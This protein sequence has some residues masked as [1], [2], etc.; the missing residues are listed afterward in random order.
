MDKTVGV[1]G[2]GQLGRMFM[3]AANRLNI[4]VNILD[5]PGAPAKQIRANSTSDPSSPAGHVDGSFKDPSSVRQLASTSDVITVE[6]E[7]VNTEILEEIDPSS[8]KVHPS[9]KTIRTIQDKFLQKLHLGEHGIATAKSIALKEGTADELERLAAELGGLPVMLKSRREAYDGRGNFAVKTKEDFPAALQALSATEELYVEQ[10]AEFRMEM[11]VI[12]VKTRDGVLSFP[13]VE[14]VHENSICKLVYAPARGVS[15]QTNEKAQALARDAVAAF[16]GKG[17][18]AVEMF[19]LQDGSLLVNEIAPRPHNSGH[20]TIEACGMS[21]YEAHLRAILDLPIPERSLRIKLPAVMLNILGAEAPDSHLE[22]ARRALSNPDTSIHL[23]GKGAARKGRKMGHVTVTAAS[24]REAED[25][26]APLVTF[27]DHQQQQQQQNGKDT[28]AAASTSTSTSQPTTPAPSPAAPTVAVVMGSD[29]DLP[30]LQAGLDTLDSFAIPHTVRITSAHR[31]PAWM[32]EYAAAAAGDGIKVI[33]AAAGGAAHLPG[34]AA[35]H[36]PLP[37]IG[38]PIK[39]SIGDGMDSLLSIVNMPRGV[40]VAA[41]S[42]NNGV[43]AALLAARILGA[44]DEGLRE[45][46]ERYMADSEAQVR[47]KDRLLDEMG[48]K[49]YAEKYLAK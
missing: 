9:W 32:A 17:V 41:V 6:I 49:A 11:A 1:L 45:K 46:Y 25:T 35:A 20:Y 18:F 23:Y 26:V 15:R 27:F 40:P 8:T 2:G 29:S 47:E 7:H 4:N 22:F 19:L 10:W 43:N 24:M 28:V 3:E 5:A 13:T 16:D 39:P 31:T 30:K 36:T 48:A 42:V 44:S 34:M 37:V 38:V 12:V 21:Q 33:I 14:T